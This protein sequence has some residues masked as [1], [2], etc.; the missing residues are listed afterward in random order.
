MIKN[1]KKKITF[2]FLIVLSAFGFCSIVNTSKDDKTVNAAGSNINQL[3]TIPGSH[4][5]VRICYT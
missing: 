4:T 2:L 5:Q 1:I 3:I